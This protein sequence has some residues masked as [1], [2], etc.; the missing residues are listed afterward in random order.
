MVVIAVG[1][2]DLLIYMVLIY[3]LC[4]NYDSVWVFSSCFICASVTFFSCLGSVRFVLECSRCVECSVFI[5]VC[6]V[7]GVGVV[8]I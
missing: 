7:S 5:L 4:S 1:S 3:A 8:I 2:I 6:D